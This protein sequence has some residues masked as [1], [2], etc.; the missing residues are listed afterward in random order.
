M[1]RIRK[2]K[3]WRYHYRKARSRCLHIK[4]YAYKF[5]GGKGI[6]FYLEPNEVKLIWERDKAYLLVKPSIDRIDSKGN[7]TF[8]NCRFVELRR[9]I[10]KSIK[11]RRRLK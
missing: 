8:D 4:H 1:R 7:Y 6:K 9:N 10:Q 5:Y 11:E 2:E 3:P